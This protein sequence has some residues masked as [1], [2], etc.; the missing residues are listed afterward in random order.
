MSETTEMMEVQ[1]KGTN[2]DNVPFIVHESAL[3]RMERQLKRVWI[4]LIVALSVLFATNIAW[5]IYESQFE[6]ISYRQD[7]AGL[8]NICTGSQGNVYGSDVT[9]QEA[10]EGEVNKSQN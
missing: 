2:P 6:T 3:A 4:A 5:L 7:G 10:E 1:E 8:N 9:D